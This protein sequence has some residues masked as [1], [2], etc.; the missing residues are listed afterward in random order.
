MAS[1]TELI[2]DAKEGEFEVVRQGGRG[3]P[4]WLN[5]RRFIKICHLIE[6][7]ESASESCRLELISYRV[8][9]LHVQKKPVYARRLKKAEEM[10]FAR[11]REIAEASII[12]AG[13]K[14]WVAHA[15][16]LERSIPE[17]F[18]LRSVVRKLNSTDQ[19]I[20]DSITE[21]E[22]KRYAAL[23]QEFQA[24]RAAVKSLNAPVSALVE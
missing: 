22:L 19:A 9:R 14:N 13:H 8:F 24:E 15:W 5:A 20:G 1:Q 10:R 17:L 21:S 2:D 7:G 18:A 16:W 23:M 6:H 3:R 4:L 12:E 11:R